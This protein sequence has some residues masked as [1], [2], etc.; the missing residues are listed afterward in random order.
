MSLPEPGS[1]APSPQ[2]PAPR[3]SG[4]VNEARRKAVR[5]FFKNKLGVAGAIIVTAFVLMAILAPY[6]APYDP[7]DQSLL[8]R[9]QTPSAAHWLGTDEFGRDILSRII[10]GARVSLGVAL[11]SVGIGLFIGSTA[12][13]IAGYVGGAVDTI[14]MR[15]MDLLLAFPYLLLA[16]VIVSALGPGMS[17]TIIAI[18]VWTVPAF[19]RV[20]RSA[21]LQIK[22]RDFVAAALALGA[23]E[24]RV[25]RVHLLPNFGATLVVYASL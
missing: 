5:R 16:I 1:A 3:G 10:Y 23:K 24:Q 8:T 25:M 4:G 14:V 7:A 2:A 17:N 18:A 21:V 22:E 11:G 15:I 12:G 19:A 6:L 13:A 9:R 20:A